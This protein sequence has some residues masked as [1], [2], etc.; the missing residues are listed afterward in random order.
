MLHRPLQNGPQMLVLCGGNL[1]PLKKHQW[2]PRGGGRSPP[3]ARLLRMPSGGTRSVLRALLAILRMSPPGQTGGMRECVKTAQRTTGRSRISR[4]AAVVAERKT[5]CRGKAL[6]TGVSPIYQ[7]TRPRR[8]LAIKQASGRVRPPWFVVVMV[9]PCSKFLR[10]QLR[11]KR[12]LGW[13]YLK[14]RLASFDDVRNA[15]ICPNHI[16]FHRSHSKPPRRC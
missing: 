1:P 12:S 9:P 8:S 11:L 14:G 10:L 4:R 7:K 2:M 16:Y 5:S 3:R 13:G 6:S 15:P